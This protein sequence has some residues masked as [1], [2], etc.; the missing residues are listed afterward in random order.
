[1]RI[2]SFNWMSFVCDCV[3]WPLVFRTHSRCFTRNYLFRAP[4]AETNAKYPFTCV[5]P[6]MKTRNALHK[7]TQN[8][9]FN[10]NWVRAW[11]GAFYN[12]CKRKMRRK[13]NWKKS[14]ERIQWL[15]G[16]LCSIWAS[17]DKTTTTA[18]FHRTFG[19]VFS[20]LPRRTRR[21]KI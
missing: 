21:K 2:I 10:S 12:N 1:M 4:N 14:V 15:V 6:E 13:K 16:W 19:H 7:H 5:L 20:T 8:E 9:Q 18:L 3:L 11:W 17:D